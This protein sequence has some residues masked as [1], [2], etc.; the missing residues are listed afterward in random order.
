MTPFVVV[1]GGGTA[2]G[3]TTLARAVAARTGALLVAQDRYYYGADDPAHFDF[4]HPDAL[5]T[6][7]LVRHLRELCAGRPVDL[8]VYDFARHA[9]AAVADR[10]DP[11]P[12][13]VVEGILTLA[14]AGLVALA[15]L[16]VFVDAPPDVRLA[17]R[18]RRD[19]AERGR[20]VEGVLD[21]Y[22]GSVRP[23]HLRFVEPSRTR[24]D[25]VLDGE[26]PVPE[27]VDALLAAV[28]ARGGPVA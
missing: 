14:H 3:K 22:L 16:R 28:A 2:S 23:G 9:R 19:T 12:L 24:A 6:D 21:Q 7:L 18:L 27:L 5:E 26:R 11:A 13:I 4:D 17:R 25:L 15:D 10:V 20:T 8:P 1:V